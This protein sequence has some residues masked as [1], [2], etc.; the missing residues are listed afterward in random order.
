MRVWVGHVSPADAVEPEILAN[1]MS[2]RKRQ[3][4]QPKS[5]SSSRSQP[6]HSLYIQA[7]EATL[8]RDQPELAAALERRD[9]QAETT[10]RNGLIRWCADGE[11]EDVWVDR[12]G[13]VQ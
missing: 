9:D 12:C 1:T 13:S 6:D 7:Y 5:S 11:E 10:A 4:H 3:T 8:I 2:K